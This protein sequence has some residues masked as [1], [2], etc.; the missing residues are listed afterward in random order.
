M[1]AL[2]LFHGLTEAMYESLWQALI[3]YL[4]ARAVL[5]LLPWMGA[6][7]RYWVLYTALFICSTLFVVKL[8]MIALYPPAVQ[9][10][11]EN[12]KT[13]AVQHS[14]FSFRSLFYHYSPEIG[15]VYLAGIVIQWIMLALSFLKAERYRYKKY[16]REDGLWQIRMD[17][18]AE[19]LGIGRKVQLYFC[20]RVL[21]PFTIGFLRP[22]IFFPIAAL[23]KL[24]VEQVEA[25]LLHELAHIKRNDFLWNILQ[26]IMEIV[27]FFNPVTWVL[28]KAIARE[29]EYCCDDIVLGK[30]LSGMIY[31]NALVKLQ[32]YQL[33]NMLA[34]KASGNDES[35]FN[36][37]K[38]L[39]SA[40]VKSGS[41]LPK[42]V[43]IT[44]VLASVLFIGWVKPEDKKR[45]EKKLASSRTEVIVED[46][47]V[48]GALQ[49]T[50]SATARVSVKLKKT[51]KG[52]IVT[53]TTVQA[54]PAA[55]IPVPATPLPPAAPALSA[56]TSPARP[57]RKIYIKS[58]KLSVVPDTCKVIV[59]R[60]NAIVLRNTVRDMSQYAIEAEKHARDIEKYF[61]SREWKRHVKQ[62]EK[63]AALVEKQSRLIEKRVQ[64]EE[65]KD[66]LKRETETIKR[67]FESPE[68]KSTLEE[69]SR[70]SEEIGRNASEMGLKISEL[71]Q[72]E[73][74][75]ELEKSRKRAEREAR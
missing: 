73:V 21:S 11:Q 9:L 57:V 1:E 71:V 75:R 23:N 45:E 2:Q 49:T 26:K 39:T 46:E 35:F 24:S 12:F 69:V 15:R 55:V 8:V 47:G 13:A 4:T 52:W 66:N 60:G 38:R 28:A 32:E 51:A 64:S 56:A 62:I 16:L 3:V 34:M 68:W 67:Y 36:R 40:E 5:F 20:S 44:A 7:F 31:A 33:E 42:A 37:I 70:T 65:W 41:A 14:A 58:G 17:K 48:P 54:E 27:L 53:D 18:L 61:E 63:H 22:A 43:I 25:I 72:K 50:E 74:E 59:T 30:N 19:N 6:E 29:R 10:M